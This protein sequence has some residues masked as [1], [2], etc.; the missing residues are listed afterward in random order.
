[1]ALC[2]H[3]SPSSMAT[4]NWNYLPHWH[5]TGRAEL[6]SL[7]PGGKTPEVIM[8]HLGWT[9]AMNRQAVNFI[10]FI[11]DNAPAPCLADDVIRN[12]YVHV[13]SPGEHSAGPL[14]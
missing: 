11:R 5:T 14:P 9:H 12:E 1:M 3:T 8:P 7:N 4:S 13:C 2:R 10:E 6:K